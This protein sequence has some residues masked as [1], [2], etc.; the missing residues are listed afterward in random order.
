MAIQRDDQVHPMWLHFQELPISMRVLYT[1]VLCVLGL[2]YCMAIGYV[3]ESHAS[4]DGKAMLSSQDLVLAYS[5]SNS[6]TRLEAA[7]AGPMK[8]MLP[9]E[10]AGVIVQWIHAD[11]KKAAFEADVVPIMEKRCMTCHDGSNPH[12][13][14][15]K[16]HENVMKMVEVDTGMTIATLI[17]VSHIHLLGITFL[18][19]IM[20]FIFSHAY[21][22]PLWFKW[23][24]TG[25][26]FAALIVDVASWYLT[27]VHSGFALVV[28]ASGFVV[29]LCVAV[30]FFISIWQMWFYTMSDELRNRH[31]N[32]KN[33]IN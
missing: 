9:P 16:G 4:R 2:G 32:A 11:A 8:G 24:T 28:M 31:K 7:L 10:E 1:G 29:G 26:P 17:R 21:V 18:F 33:L 13:P 3:F 30:M 27:K 14:T 12:L 22:R 19:F 20:G 5:G 15:L 23:V 6:N 25:A